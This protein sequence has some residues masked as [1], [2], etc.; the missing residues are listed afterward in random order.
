M[1]WW[2]WPSLSPASWNALSLS[3]TF[4]SYPHSLPL[5]C[6]QFSPNCSHLHSTHWQKIVIM[7]FVPVT[8]SMWRTTE[9]LPSGGVVVSPIYPILAFITLTWHSRPNSLPDHRVSLPDGQSV[10]GKKRFVKSCSC[11]RPRQCSLSYHFSF[12]SIQ[13]VLE[14]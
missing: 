3:S 7:R 1:R 13:T 5:L 12:L 8:N 11:Q 14:C 10:P 2:G 4:F 6:Y 9:V